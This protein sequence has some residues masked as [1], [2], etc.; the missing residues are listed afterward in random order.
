MG[1]TVPVVERTLPDGK[2]AAFVAV[3]ARFVMEPTEVLWAVMGAQAVA[4][5]TTAISWGGGLY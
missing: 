5:D 1:I 3:E 2:V 4:E